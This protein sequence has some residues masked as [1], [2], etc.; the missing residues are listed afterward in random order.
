[1]NHSQPKNL[2]YGKLFLFSVVLLLLNDLY[3]KY[4][5]HNYLTGKLSDF[6]GLFAFPY[7]VSLFFKSRIKLIYI[8][9]GLLF[10]FWKSTFSQ[11][12]LDFFNTLGI[13][14]NR[15][16]DYSDLVALLI[17][18]FSYQYRKQRIFANEPLK[19]IPK[20]I[21]IGVCCFAFVA[22]SLPSESGEINL[23]SDYEVQFETPKDTILRKMFR[24]YQ[25]NNDPYYE[26]VI[27]LPEKNSRIFVSTIIS[28]FGN[29]K[30][31]IKLD[32]ILFFQTESSG[33]FWGVK[34]KNVNYVKKLKVADFEQLFVE[35]EISKLKK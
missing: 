31:K 15:I 2:I 13:G 26:M 23:K 30:T 20:S 17:I 5:F 3:F 27:E 32:S 10:V 18:P 35:Q 9:T 29:N 16:V 4:Y 21:I 34:K 12:V 8:L 7:F 19:F 1:M 25:S 6:V 28:E 22:T 24:Y 14:I 33:L 11:F